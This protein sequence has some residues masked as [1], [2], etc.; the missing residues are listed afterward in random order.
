MNPGAV[1]DIAAGTAAFAGLL[2]IAVIVA[3]FAERVRV[4]AAV[5]FVAVGLLFPPFKPVAIPFTF[6]A[7][8]LFVYLPPLI[9][10]A[11]WNLELASLRRM[12]PAIAILALP[13]VVASTLVVAFGVAATG[14]L[15]L[16]AAFMLG[17]IV[18]ATDPVA[19]IAIFR[20]LNVPR[21]LQTMIE[22]ES[23]A[24]DGVAIALYGVALALA[25]TPGSVDFLSSGGHAILAIVGGIAIGGVTA[26]AF[27]FAIRSARDHATELAATIVLAY[28]AY[29]FANALDLSG[30][31][32]TAA[33]GIILRANRNRFVTAQSIEDVDRFWEVIAFIAN[34]LVFLST[35]LLIQANRIVHEPVLVSVSIA[36]IFA[37]RALLAFGVLPLLNV[38]RN[39]P[40]WRTTTFF[41]G[42]RGALSLAL[43]L[44]LPDGFPHRPEIIDATFAIVFVTLVVQGAALE[45]VLQRLP[46]QRD[47]R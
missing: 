9:F 29:G 22:G 30:V 21:D 41:S 15:P 24:N 38:R 3:I 31:F 28:A 6:G 7:T 1:T 4:P 23:I 11:A 5:A 10:E 8:L 43:A 40:G 27:G 16:V 39:R 25:A 12:G 36:A 19:V 42:M 17:T 45:P 34:A 18:S 37:A 26:V 14:Q 20:R 33:A 46:L 44:G 35:G 2:G 13:G 47:S 32:A